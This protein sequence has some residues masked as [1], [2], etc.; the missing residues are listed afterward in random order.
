MDTLRRR[1]VDVVTGAVLAGAAG[2]ALLALAFSTAVHRN[3]TAATAFTHRGTWTYEAPVP[4]AT[5]FV[6]AV[7]VTGQPIFSNL[8][9]QA[10]FEFRYSASSAAAAVMSGRGQL[11]AEMR[12][13]SGWTWRIPMGQAAQF[14]GSEA[15]LRGRLEIGS[16]AAIA[17]RFREATGVARPV[18]Q[19]A[20]TPALTVT[21]ATESGS[22]DLSFS[23]ELLFRYDA[24]GLVPFQSEAAGDPGGASPVQADNIERPIRVGNT[25]RVLAWRVDVRLARLAGLVLLELAVLALLAVMLARTQASPEGAA[26]SSAGR[27][28]PIVVRS[29][30]S[31]AGTPTVEVRSLDELVR[32][33]G[34]EDAPLLV[35]REAHV[36]EYA[37]VGVGAVYVFREFTPFLVRPGAA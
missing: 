32:L 13:A 36:A 19:V 17:D 30:P 4:D 12:E 23:P 20:V 18:F 6:G 35:R 34:F 31:P 37:V 24:V 16:L 33:S 25:I 14:T 2:L 8:S 9:D 15:V 1:A 26:G 10:T 7:A 29:L 3:A 11:V 5:L 21:V 28:R 22:M 27:T